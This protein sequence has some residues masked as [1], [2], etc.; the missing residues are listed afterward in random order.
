MT[1]LVEAVAGE[2]VTIDL[3]PFFAAGQLLYGGAFVAER[4]A[5]V[6]AFVD[7]G[8][9]DIDPVV[10]QIIRAAAAIPAWQLARDGDVL[11]RLRR[12]TEATWRTA[13]VLVVPTVPRL[14]TVAEV[15][16]D[17]LG[18]NAML[19][20]YTTFANLL[21]LCGLTL[22]TEPTS[23]DGPPFSVTL[24]GPAWADERLASVARRLSQTLGTGTPATRRA[25]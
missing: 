23:P 12:T 18:P 9:D 11:A 10:G 20:T 25:R 19:G 21:G 17:P 5:A 1:D 24:L 22:P 4:Y 6:G 8:T 2:P 14:P 3:D 15:T 7:R 16:A 13:D